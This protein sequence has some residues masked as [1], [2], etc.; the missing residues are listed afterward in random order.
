MS[1]EL[2]R[3]RHDH[4]GFPVRNYVPTTV[5]FL[6]STDYIR[7]ITVTWQWLDIVPGSENKKHTPFLISVLL[8]TTENEWLA[9]G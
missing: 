6:E 8:G 1:A 4:F 7:V 5:P 3:A 2:Y 9:S